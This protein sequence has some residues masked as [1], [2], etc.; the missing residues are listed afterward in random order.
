MAMLA[1]YGVEED[2][3]EL[4]NRHLAYAPAPWTVEV[5]EAFRADLV[6]VSRVAGVEHD[7][8]NTAHFLSVRLTDERVLTY[9]YRVMT[10]ERPPSGCAP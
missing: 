1:R 10:T 5:M 8:A 9:G 4:F 6:L 7:A 2:I 3:Q